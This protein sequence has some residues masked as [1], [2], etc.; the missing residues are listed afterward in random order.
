MARRIGMIVPPA[1]GALPPEAYELF[2]EGVVFTAR[3]LALRELSVEGYS[4][5]IDRV[6]D[7]SRALKTEDGAEAVSLM[8]TSLSFF[9]GVAFND[10]LVERMQAAT[11]LPATTMSN[12]IRDG[13]RAVGARRIAVGTAYTDEVN[14]LLRSYLEALGFE[15]LAVESFGLSGVAEIHAVGEDSIVQLGERAVAAAGPAAEGLL[16]SCGG[17]RTLDAAPRLEAR[18]GLPAVTSATAGVWATAGLLG[19]D[20]TDPRLGRL[21]QVAAPFREGQGDQV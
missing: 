18:T 6:L 21:G 5:V 1:D 4:A 17:L 11:G 2:P 9:R 13:L 10:D 19:L 14:A 15:V 7:L 16:I 12:A 8:G 3:G 20:C